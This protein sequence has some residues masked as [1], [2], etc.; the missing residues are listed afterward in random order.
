MPEATFI[1]PYSEDETT[2]RE[3]IWNNLRQGI[4]L[5]DK[6]I[7][8]PWDMSYGLLDQFAEQMNPQGDRTY[9]DLGHRTILSGYQCRIIA[10]RW[11]YKKLSEPFDKVEQ[12]LGMEYDGHERFQA[13]RKRLTELLGEPTRVDLEDFNGLEI[14]NVEWKQGDVTVILVGI[15]Q[16]ACKYWLY[17]GRFN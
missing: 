17:V 8:L 11:L 9:W 15:E 6:G 5:E 7:F 1:F 14:G 16:F 2:R 13:V 12:F 3:Q 10:K 4:L